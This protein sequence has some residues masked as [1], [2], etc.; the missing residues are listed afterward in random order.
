MVEREEL[1]ADVAVCRAI[2]LVLGCED[3]AGDIVGLEVVGESGGEVGLE[4]FDSAGVSEVFG[5]GGELV[6][7]E[8]A[9]GIGGDD[10]FGF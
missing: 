5:F 3:G 7:G 4:D 10:D 2:R 6:E 8:F 1:P 9:S